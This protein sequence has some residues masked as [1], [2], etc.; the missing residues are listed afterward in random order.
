MR[1]SLNNRLWSKNILS[2]KEKVLGTAISKEG[3][4]NSV[5]GHERT[6]HY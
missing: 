4:A 2:G 6:H 1:L 3:H 5:Q